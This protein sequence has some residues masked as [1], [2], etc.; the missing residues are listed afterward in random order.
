MTTL[1]G[2]DFN[3][4][5]GDLV[6]VIIKAT[7][8]KGS[9]L[10]SLPNIV[11]ALVEVMPSA[12]TTAPRRGDLTNEFRID[13]EWDFISGYQDRGGTN[14][15]SYELQI[16]DGN[17]GFFI[18][19]VGFTSFYTLNSFLISSNINSGLTYRL[20]YRAHNV[21]G[22]SGFSPI[23]EI[24]AATIPGATDEPQTAIV[25][26]DVVL[27]WNEPTNTGGDNIA[28]TSYSVEILLTDDTYYEI[29]STANT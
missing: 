27:S 2:S 10:Y 17:G 8:E 26:T 9:G 21:H 23:A 18:E 14:I 7:N 6:V 11:G 3:L 24:L 28:I 4:Q 1:I 25:G 12:P 20:Q 22:W 5:L 15:D 13:V 29:C 19:V 16:D